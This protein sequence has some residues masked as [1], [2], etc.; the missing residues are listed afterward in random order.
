MNGK[1]AR[2]IAREWVTREAARLPDF[3]GAWFAGSAIWLPDEAELPLTSDVDVTLVH[4]GPTDR[5]PPK[6]GKFMHQGVVLDV[7][8]IAFHEL[9]STDLILGNYHLAAS[10]DERNIIA[11]TTGA[12]TAL[13]ATVSKEYAKRLWVSRRCDHAMHKILGGHGALDESAPFHHQVLSWLFPTGVTTH[14]LLVAGLRNAT[15]RQRYVAVR[16]LLVDYDRLAFHDDL[17][18]L[19]GCVEMSPSRVEHHLDNLTALFDVVK[20][21]ARS[22]FAFASDIS[23]LARPIAIDGSRDLISRGYHR[24]AVFWIVATW[25]R[26]LAVLHTDVPHLETKEHERGYRELLGD[27]GIASYHDLRK[28]GKRVEAFLPIVRNVADQ[29][30]ASNPDVHD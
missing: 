20:D 12:L 19:L 9:R 25:S 8:W 7:S 26:C 24:E 29:I 1:R 27:L 30:I 6:P 23:E 11:D 10:F 18:G 16:D 15:V 3:R 28:R 22:P 2:E 5:P 21:R 4:A 17:L 14:V 13:S